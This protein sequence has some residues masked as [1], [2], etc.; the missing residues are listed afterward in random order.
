MIP[1]SRPKRSDLY[2]KTI[3]FTAAHTYIAHIWQYPPRDLP[4]KNMN[5]RGRGGQTA[6]NDQSRIINVVIHR[7]PNKVRQIRTTSAYV[8]RNKFDYQ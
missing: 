8:K 6:V 5:T 1:Y 7:Q 4:V 2:T 3:P